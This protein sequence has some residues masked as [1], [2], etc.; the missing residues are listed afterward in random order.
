MTCDAVLEALLDAE[1]SALSPNDHSALGAHLRGCARCRRIAAQL[2]ADVR[3]L[4]TGVEAVNARVRNRRIRRLTIAP[5]FAAAV[6]TL[7]LVRR[8]APTVSVVPAVVVS[9]APD[10]EP[11]PPDPRPRPRVSRPAKLVREFPRP[12]AVVP[13]QFERPATPVMSEAV[14]VSNAVQVDPPPGVRAAILRTGDPKLVVVWL[15]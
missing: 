3:L 15:Y 14:V 5:A 2:E 8:E 9:V 4:A 10:R 13:V 11:T 1:P 12:V 7:L 6:M